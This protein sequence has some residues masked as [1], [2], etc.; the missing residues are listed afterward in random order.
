MKN[1]SSNEEGSQ[2][3]GHSRA[4]CKSATETVALVECVFC[5]EKERDLSKMSKKQKHSQK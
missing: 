4:K 5:G 3:F 1:K 2:K